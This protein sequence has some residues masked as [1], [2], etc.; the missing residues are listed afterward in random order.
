MRRINYL[1]IFFIAEIFSTSQTSETHGT[2]IVNQQ[3]KLLKARMVR[4]R[5]LVSL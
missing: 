2:T 1:L 3:I 5:N 4:L